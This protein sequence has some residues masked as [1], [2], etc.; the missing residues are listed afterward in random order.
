MRTAPKGSALWT[1][2]PLRRAPK[3]PALWTPAGVIDP[4]PRDAA[5]SPLRLRA[6]RGIWV[7]CPF[8][9]H[10]WP[11]RQKDGGPAGQLRYII[12]FSFIK[13]IYLFLG[14]NKNG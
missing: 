11:P 3:G 4:R 8:I 5:A 1:P 14:G 12:G 7:H 13:T 10:C 2:A 9:L 6:G